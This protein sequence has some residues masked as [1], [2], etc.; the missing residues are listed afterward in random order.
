MVAAVRIASIKDRTGE[1]HGRLTVLRFEKR[2]ERIYWLCRCACGKEKAFLSHNLHPKASCGCLAREERAKRHTTHGMAR[3]P[4]YIAWR[5]MIDRCTNHKSQQYHNY[6][7]RGITVCDRWL[8]FENFYAD[9]GPRP[10]T[11]GERSKY[12]LERNDND[13]N[14]EP[15]NVRW[16]TQPEQRRNCRENVWLE[17]DGRRMI[18]QDWANHLSMDA[19]T[20]WNRINQY[21][22]SVEDALTTPVPVDGR[23]TRRYAVR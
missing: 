2:G 9:V 16:A 19:N 11:D 18:L 13:G 12:S 10:T 5:H 6:G 23:S 3:S 17:W 22:W 14:Y 15:G 1:T 4:E 7:G 8:S 21:G 20:L